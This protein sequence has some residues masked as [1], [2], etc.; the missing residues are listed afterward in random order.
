[1]DAELSTLRIAAGIG[2]ALGSKLVVELAETTLESKDT[3]IGRLGMAG[4]VKGEKKNGFATPLIAY[5]SRFGKFR[6]I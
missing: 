6:Q 4:G 5:E 2:L 3:G 1:M